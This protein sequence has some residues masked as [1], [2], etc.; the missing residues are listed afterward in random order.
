MTGRIVDNATERGV[1]RVAFYGRVVCAERPEQDVRWQ[2]WAVRSTL[3]MRG[4][5]V[6][7]FADIGPWSGLGAEGR[8]TTGWCL[9]GHF[10]EGGIDQLLDRA[11]GPHRD[12]DVIACVDRIRLSRRPR[13]SAMIEDTLAHHGLRVIT[14]DGR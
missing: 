5:I 13:E 11:A 14:P 4:F 2:L 8:T 1:V 10:V 3:G 6:K 12:F 9:D 7:C